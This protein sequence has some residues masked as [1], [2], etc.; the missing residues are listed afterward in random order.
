MSTFN[1][2]RSV[3]T[4]QNFFYTVLLPYLQ[5]KCGYGPFMLALDMD[6]PGYFPPA[7]HFGE[8]ELRRDANINHGAVVITLEE[9]GS[10][11]WIPISVKFGGAAGGG[12]FL[13][14]PST[15]ATLNIDKAVEASLAWGIP[16]YAELNGLIPKNVLPIRSIREVWR[17]R[18]FDHRNPNVI[19]R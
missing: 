14:Y 13:A 17:T 6:G 1:F 10:G 16:T 15:A 18:V 9:N 11:D 5:E 4:V 19:I 8:Q 12:E 7:G 3:A 2:T